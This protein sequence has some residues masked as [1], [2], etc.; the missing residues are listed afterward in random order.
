MLVG[1]RS[2]TQ[3]SSDGHPVKMLASRGT[4]DFKDGDNPESQSRSHNH[5][6]AWFLES[7]ADPSSA[8][9][10]W[11]E[12]LGLHPGLALQGLMRKS[13]VKK[14]GGEF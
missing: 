4:L 10:S 11:P 6:Q 7:R 12:A 8:L 5:N 1:G 2:R 9:Q 3:F 13:Q 14:A